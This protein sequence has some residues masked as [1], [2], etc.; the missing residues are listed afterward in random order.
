[1]LLI[2]VLYRISLYNIEAIEARNIAE[3]LY[4]I[5]NSKFNK[6]IKFTFKQILNK[7]TIRTR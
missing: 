4:F 1:M 2:R 5:N 6:I 3:I 7:I